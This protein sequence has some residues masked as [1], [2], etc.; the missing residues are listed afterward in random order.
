MDKKTK[1]ALYWSPRIISILL[2]A[3]MALMSLD[4][5]ESGG[6]AWDIAVGLFMHNL[7]VFAMIIILIFAWKYEIVGGIA[8]ILA[9]AAYVIW[10][11]ASGQP[12][13]RVLSWSLT[14]AGPAFLAGGL[15]LVNWYRKKKN[16]D[17]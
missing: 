17:Q 2:I 13:Y 7:P 4:V 5:F 14:I 15:F 6:S 8:F 10:V 3:L 16:A 1:G 9:G 11:A 12:W